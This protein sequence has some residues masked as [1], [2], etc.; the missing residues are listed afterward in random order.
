M[1]NII[2]VEN[3][4][5]TYKTIDTT[6]YALQDV[7]F[8]I[9]EGEILA[10]MGSSGS[11]K[12]TLL[13]ILGT[14]DKPD[15]GKIYVNNCNEKNYWMEPRATEIRGEYIGFIYQNFNLLNDFTVEENI[16]LPLILDGDKNIKDDIDKLM[17]LVGLKSRKNHRP[18]ELSG[19]Q[20]Q[21]VAIARALVKRPKLLL[22]DEPTGNLDYKTTLEIMDFLSKAN[23]EEKQ[24]IVI[25]T[26]DPIVAAYAHRVL[27]F[28]DGKMMETHSLKEKENKLDFIMST[29]KRVIN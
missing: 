29:F 2:R 16:A 9:E 22:A 11:G 6:I 17:D 19:G 27:F 26:H 8:G 3:I 28:K 25:V 13:H 21:R 4:T 18:S 24:T 5:K 7:S 23:R 14:I 20:Q 12:S 10:I 15:S 1:S